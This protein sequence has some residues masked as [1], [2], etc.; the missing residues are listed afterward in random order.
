LIHSSPASLIAA[1]AAAAAECRYVARLVEQ[2]GRCAR[3]ATVAGRAREIDDRRSRRSSEV[4]SCFSQRPVSVQELRSRTRQS[5]ASAA[6]ESL[7]TAGRRHLVVA[8]QRRPDPL[9]GLPAYAERCGNTHVPPARAMRVIGT[10]TEREAR[11]TTAAARAPRP[12]GANASCV[13]GSR[14]AH[15]S[16]KQVRYNAGQR[17]SVH[18]ERAAG[19]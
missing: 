13:A 6:G 14:N 8:G 16:R 9:R 4:E 3:S 5:G 7:T 17:G 15:P 12:R 19:H 10:G 1:L 2:H 18:L 11:G